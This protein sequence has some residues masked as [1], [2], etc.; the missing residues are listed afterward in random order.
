MEGIFSGIIAVLVFVM[1]FTI[2]KTVK[3][4]RQKKLFELVSWSVIGDYNPVLSRYS[5]I[6]ELIFEIRRAQKMIS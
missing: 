5:Y 1:V 4:Y 3:Y 6:N 2:D